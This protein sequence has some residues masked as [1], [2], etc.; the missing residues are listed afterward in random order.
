MVQGSGGFP[1]VISLLS[2][3][4]YNRGCVEQRPAPGRDNLHVGAVSRHRLDSL[5]SSNELV[6]KKK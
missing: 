4:N 3:C 6:T 1:S 2:I 5:N